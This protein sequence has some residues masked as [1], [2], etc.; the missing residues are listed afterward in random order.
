MKE[1]LM[2][3]GRMLRYFLSRTEKSQKVYEVLRDIYFE[4]FSMPVNLR[5]F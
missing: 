2:D 3:D 4:E 5:L 1:R